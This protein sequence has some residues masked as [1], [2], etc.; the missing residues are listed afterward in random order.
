ML[1]ALF[2]VVVFISLNF[3][4][5]FLYMPTFY[6]LYCIG[7]GIV[8]SRKLKTVFVVMATVT[9]TKAALYSMSFSSHT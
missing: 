8:F 9:M 1:L 3:C 5:T 6:A 7:L 4:K 2:F